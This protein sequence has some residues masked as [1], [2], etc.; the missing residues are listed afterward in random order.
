[1]PHRRSCR[2]SDCNVCGSDLIWFAPRG[3]PGS[4][5]VRHSP[6]ADCSGLQRGGAVSQPVGVGRLALV[7][8]GVAAAQC[9]SSTARCS[10]L[11]CGRKP[12]PAPSL[13]GRRRQPQHS[14][15][16]HRR[17]R[18][19]R[20]R[21]PIEVPEVV[22][23]RHFVEQIELSALPPRVLSTDGYQIRIHSGLGDR[24]PRR[25]CFFVPRSGRPPGS[26]SWA[27]AARAQVLVVRV[28]GVMNQ[29]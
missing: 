28:V 11:Q 29:R 14:A 8:V 1:V 17:G 18:P 22:G 16:D 4:G 24:D 3:D 9:S 20:H 13:A 25:T 5:R 19:K 6:T 10:T 21:T 23:V 15:R 27:G 12:P 26:G 2:G 7:E